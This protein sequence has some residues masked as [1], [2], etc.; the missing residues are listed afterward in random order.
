M[1]MSTTV[2]E[3]KAVHMLIQRIRIYADGR[4]K[5]MEKMNRTVLKAS[6]GTGKTYRLSLEFIANLIKGTDYRNIVVMTFTKKATA[7]IKERIYDFLYQIAFEKYNWQDIEKNLKEIYGLEDSQINKKKLQEIYFNIIRNKDEM[8]IYTIDGFTNRIFK[9]TIAPFF[10]IYNFE[11]IDEE[12]EEFYGNILGKILE[13]Q[14]YFEKFLFLVEEKKE[15]KEIGVYINL[16]KDILNIQNYF[17]LSE[18]KTDFGEK[19]EDISFVNYLEETFKH[20]EAIAEIKNNGKKGEIKPVTNFINDDFHIIYKEFKNIDE[21]I[22]DKIENKREKIEIVI[23]NW[24]IFYKGEGFKI[25]NGRTVKGKEIGN[26]IEEIDNLK[27]PFMKSLSK[28]IFTKK[29]VPLH[30]KMTEI[31]EIIYSIAENEKRKSKRFT[32]NDVSV[33]TYKFIFD[34]EL[35]F[36]QENGVTKDFLELIGGEIETIMID[37]FQDTSVLQWKILSLLMESAKNIICVG[38]E[39]QSIYGWRGG[40]KEL[41]EKLDKII[42]GKVENLDKSYRSYKQVIEN[43]NRIYEGYDKKWEYLPVKY[44]DDKDYQGGYFSYCLREVPR[45]S[46]VAR[47]YE[48]IVYLIKEGKIKNLGKSCILCRTNTQIQNIVKRLNEENIPYTLNNNASILDHEAI[49]P[50]YKLIKYFVFHNFIYFLEFMRSD[51]I[52]CLN[53]HVGYL[54]ENKSKIEEYMRDG[55]RETFSEYVNRQE[56][57][58]AEKL[59]KYEEIDKMNRNSLLFSDVLYKIKELKKLAKNLNSK[60]EKENFSQKIIENFNV[61]NFYPTNSDIKNIF[62]FFNILKENDDLFEFVS[63]M[64]EEKDKIT[65]VS[66]SDVEAINLMSIH[67]SK[68]LEF[69]TVFYYKSNTESNKTDDL[70]VYFEYDEKYTKLDKFLLTFGKYK[71]TFIDGYYSNIKENNEYKKEMEEINADYVALTRAK[72]NLLLFF[73][74]NKSGGKGLA[75]RL[76]DVYGKNERY[77]CGEITESEKKT[78]DNLSGNNQQTDEKLNRIMP[79][80]SNSKVNFPVK[81][82][83]ITLKEE[84]KRKKGLAIHYYFEHILNNL[85]EDRKTARS[86]L[87]SRYGNMLGKTIL[88]EIISRLEEFISKNRD[89]YDKKYKVYTEF[90]IYDSEGNKK[91]M[92]RINID[93]ENK[94]IYIFDYKTGYEPLENEIYIQ[95]IENY[96]QILDKKLAG[97]YEIYT[98]ILEV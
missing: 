67:K 97:E 89:I 33:Y 12:D 94:K 62:N 72:K 68:G 96:K 10:G 36:V 5:W 55:K 59:K 3:K 25:K 17:I 7:E 14:E 19:K 29:V 61:I 54:L 79:Y 90:E 47:T 82:F 80:F 69:D 1:K 48:D 84:F 51:L 46:G 23:K 58:T 49:I 50:L 27:E 11:T 44:R 83:K 16:I 43:V 65:Q 40:E 66:S 76:I 2:L 35:N 45:G 20:I 32:H 74:T 85:E 75:K 38:D 53:D 70:E 4:M 18:E 88:I 42:D 8:R 57:A 92:D 13:N 52:G 39:K 9:N 34:R 6:A 91:I 26:F 21:M 22:K 95:Q 37:E 63:F 93:E 86:A 73:D 77:E 78:E 71:K 31:A 28:N 41:F 56:G 24:E 87:L 81:D 30:E 98:R 15:K 60:Y 64:E